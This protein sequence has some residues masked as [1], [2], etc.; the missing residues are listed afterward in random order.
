MSSSSTESPKHPDVRTPNCKPT[1]DVIGTSLNQPHKEKVS[2]DN[3]KMINYTVSSKGLY[4]HPDTSS[5][6][7]PEQGCTTNKPFQTVQPVLN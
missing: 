3:V 4:V 6:D 2:N 1:K 7:K 5:T